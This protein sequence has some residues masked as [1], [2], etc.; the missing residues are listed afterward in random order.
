MNDNTDKLAAQMRNLKPSKKSREAG[1]DAAM[2]AFSKEFS[3]ETSAETAQSNAVDSTDF[4][5]NSTSTQG[6]ADTPRPTGKS[7]TTVRAKTRRVETMAKIKTAF[8]F[9]PHTM[10]MS[11]TCSAALIAAMIVIPN[12]DQLGPSEQQ[13]AVAPVEVAENID[14]VE[15]VD[16][17]GDAEAAG[18]VPDGMTDA[19]SL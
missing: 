6:S 15:P 1:L 11:G 2:A 19:T 4:E 9:K 10:M 13:I 18:N 5:K 3:S 17:R 7:T 14:A 12:M 8:N 16:I